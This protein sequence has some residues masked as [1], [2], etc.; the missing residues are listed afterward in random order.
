[1]KAKSEPR[2]ATPSAFLGPRLAA[3]VLVALSLVLIWSALGI[4]RG[5]GYQL[6]GPAT[7][8]LV[9]ATGL[10]IL[11]S[12]FALRTTLVPD[13]DLRDR[14][15]GEEQA[16]DWRMV[17]MVGLTLFAYA[18]AL[19]GFELGPLDVPGLGYVISTG[20][21]LPIAARVLGSRS[22]IR[23]VLA[24]FGLALVVYAGFTQYLGVRL[25]AGLLDF[26]P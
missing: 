11:S 19:D 9:V 17:A 3:G 25:P 2:K 12:T 6:I 26:V 22:P 5:G 13:A 21:F 16:C 23:D 14:A 20:V 1:M 24:A 7:I 10:L 15:H 4:A 18:F 8:P